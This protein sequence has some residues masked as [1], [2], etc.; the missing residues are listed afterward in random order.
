MPSVVLSAGCMGS[1]FSALGP[2]DVTLASSDTRLA[3]AAAL[4]AVD[5]SEAFDGER[6]LL[7]SAAY[8]LSMLL[9]PCLNCLPLCWTLLE[10]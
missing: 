4:V 1:F 5:L 7:S 10:C 8:R 3:E 2:S 6:F 9:T